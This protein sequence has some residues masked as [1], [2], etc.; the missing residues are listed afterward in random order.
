MEKYI[1]NWM[2]HFPNAFFVILCISLA[3]DVYV[4]LIH[5]GTIK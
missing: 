1:P 3:F 4:L 5:S 2:T